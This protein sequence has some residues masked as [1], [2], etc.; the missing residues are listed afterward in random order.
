V[1]GAGPALQPFKIRPVPGRV[2]HVQQWG[3]TGCRVVELSVRCVSGRAVGVLVKR[4]QH[5][6]QLVDV[7]VGQGAA[8]E[9]VIEQSKL[10]E[11]RPAI[12]ALQL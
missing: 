8:R 3:E 9:H 7:L 1:L 11:W 5:G 4:R 6:G 2:D 12:S 10:A